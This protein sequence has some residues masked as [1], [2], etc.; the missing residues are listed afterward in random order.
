MFKRI[1]AA[2]AV[3]ALAGLGLAVPSAHAATL[4]CTSTESCGGADLLYAAKGNLSLAVLD[5]DSTINGGFGYNNEEVGFTTSGA[6]NGTQD[7]TVSQ[8]SGETA[9]KGGVY[10]YGD[11]VA[12]FTPGGVTAPAGDLQYCVSVEDTYPVVHG[13]TTQRWGL[14]LRNCD[15]NGRTEFSA[16]TLS[17]DAESMVT[18]PDLYQLWAPTEVPGPALEFQDVALNSQHLRHG[19][20]G[21]NFVMDD[22]AFG[23]SGTW[24]LAF[25]ENDQPNHKLV[26]DGCTSPIDKFN[27]AYF[28]CASGAVPAPVTPLDV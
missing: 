4:K 14:V 17:D 13:K 9:G 16:G 20:G 12:R 15:A 19:F 5:P 26:I 21:D 25:E 28:N 8:E 7:F 27:T 11:Y 24:G 10:G 1:L 6:T 18:N 22:R 23:G 2:G 3:A